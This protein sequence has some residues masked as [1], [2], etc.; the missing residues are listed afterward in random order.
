M[1]SNRL[2]GSLAAA[3]MLALVLPADAALVHRETS[4]FGTL[5]VHDEAGERCL[6]FNPRRDQRQTC[7]DLDEPQRLVFEYYKGM[8][9]ALYL[10]SA[11]RR[12][13]VIG[14]GGGA[15]P[16]ALQRLFPALEMDIVEIDPAVVRVARKFFGFHPAAGTHIHEEDGRAF[17]Q[18]ARKAGRQY[19]LVMLDA[20]DPDYIPAHLMTLEFLL[21]LKDLLAEDG[22][23]AANTFST[24]RLQQQETATYFG[25]F[26]AF[27]NLK[28]GNRII[29]ATR[30][31]IPPLE[32]VSA[33][34]KALDERLRPL[35]IERQELL[36]RFTLQQEMPRN[37]RVL[38]D[39]QLPS[40]TPGKK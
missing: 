5:Y 38:S 17:V 11:P 25:A 31:G 1:P 22:V 34:A 19:D 8:M 36:M 10:N 18:R 29:L 35:G 33:S 7:I 12:V 4:A 30:D 15:L 40:G 20:F 2:P 3:L 23:V 13:L 16:A 24:S 6:S 32:S 26:G 9:A 28:G 39:R 21:E 37:A 27:Y 14:L